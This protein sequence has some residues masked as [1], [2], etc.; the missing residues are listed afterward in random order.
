[1]ARFFL[2]PTSRWRLPPA[3][4][5]YLCNGGYGQHPN[6]R[7]MQCLHHITEYIMPPTPQS[8]TLS[9]HAICRMQQRGFTK[10]HLESVLDYGRVAHIKGSALT[11][12][13]IGRSE[14]LHFRKHGIDL[15]LCEGIHV[16]AN[17]QHVITLYRANTTRLIKPKSRYKTAWFE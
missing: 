16:L 4:P 9:N 6:L 12:H 11:F 7:L 17:G 8:Y 13:F 3:C 5:Y 2:K 15:K 1:M 10:Q 14:V